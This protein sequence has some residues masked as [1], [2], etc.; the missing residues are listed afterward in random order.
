MRVATIVGARPQFIKAA[1]LSAALKEAGVEEVMIHTG[2][3]YDYAMS[4]LFFE[5][6]GLAAPA[7]NLG[8]GSAS[9]G[10]QTARILEAIEQV[11]LA[12]KF[13]MLVVY[14]DTNSTLAGAL[15]AAKLL[16][17]VAH[18]EA[19]LRSFNR[20]MP[21][22]INRVL[23]D[24]VSDLLFAPTEGA[25]AN[26]VREGIDEKKIH[27]TGDVMFDAVLRFQP[28]FARERIRETLGLGERQ[29]F[30]A[31]IHRAENTDDPAR[32]DAIVRAFET[33]ASEVAPIVWPLH[34]RTRGKL[35]Q[36]VRGVQLIDP[37]GYF[38][39]QALLGAARGALTDSGGLQKEAA[40][41]GVPTITLRD[42]TETVASGAN[43][44]VG[45]DETRIVA[46]AR[47]A[48][49]RVAPPAGFGRGNAAQIIS[50]AIIEWIH[51]RQ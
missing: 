6:L 46:A 27:V 4:E 41:H 11:L 28:L 37:I 29:Y 22:E 17:P 31:T 3:H 20:R 32:L 39:M 50:S 51:C 9:H 14:G 7:H 25:V 49:G 1:I 16:I 38:E 42:E 2:Q 33:I 36:T 44:L 23:T 24:H 18:V 30:V 48:S 13:D 8:V 5:Q 45:A 12:D 47:A 34:P 10:A 19:G 15:A 21:E 40:F 43:V 35:Q 26:L